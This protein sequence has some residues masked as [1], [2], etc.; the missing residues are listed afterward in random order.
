MGCIWLAPDGELFLPT[1]QLTS[2][3]EREVTG[4]VLYLH[5]SFRASVM[6][7]V[8]VFLCAKLKNGSD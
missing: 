2:S 1:R 7:L 3:A 5:A 4:Y 8:T 6:N